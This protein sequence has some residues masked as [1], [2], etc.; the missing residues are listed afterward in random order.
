MPTYM[1]FYICLYIYMY[2]D[3]YIYLHIYIYIYIYIY[4]PSTLHGAKRRHV[5]RDKDRTTKPGNYAGRH[6]SFKFI[7]HMKLHVQILNDTHIWFQII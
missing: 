5:E 7:R 1:Y 3:I 2:I 6:M 4:I